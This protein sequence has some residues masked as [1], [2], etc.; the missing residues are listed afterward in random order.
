M[1]RDLKK[2]P[3]S[4]KEAK[5]DEI[6]DSLVSLKCPY[7][8]GDVTALL[9]PGAVR[10]RILLWC[11]EV[12][13]PELV[14]YSKA[15]ITKLTKVLA[16]LGLCREDEIGLV[17]GTT[18]KKQHEFLL[19]LFHLTSM[20]ISNVDDKVSRACLAV[21]HVCLRGDL[22]EIL[23]SSISLIPP[24][25]QYAAK[26]AGHK[27]KAPTL[28]QLERQQSQ[29]VEQLKEI[30]EKLDNSFSRDNLQ[31]VMI[32]SKSFPVILGTL[33]QQLTA[34]SHAF[35]QEFRPYVTSVP[36]ELNGD[37]LQLL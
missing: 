32:K 13:H 10:N 29:L 28:V 5:G 36:L 37:C 34:Y 19:T 7:F 15:D 14:E 9:K 6:L 33:E 24:T 30:Q 23:P 26:G 16:A 22:S 12:M 17:Q 20:E 35:E 31:A 11:V 25:L 3:A 2:E 1:S 27:H 18:Q 4:T 8:A 21:N